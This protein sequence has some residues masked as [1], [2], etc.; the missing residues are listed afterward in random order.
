MVNSWTVWMTWIKIAKPACSPL[1]SFDTHTSKYRPL[2]LPPFPPRDSD[3]FSEKMETHPCNSSFK[4]FLFASRFSQHLLVRF[5]VLLPSP[6]DS[7][8]GAF[9]LATFL[10]H[11]YWIQFA[12]RPKCSFLFATTRSGIT[13]GREEGW[14]ETGENFIQSCGNR[15]FSSLRL[16]LESIAL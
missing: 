10:L 4:W 13:E 7:C 2:F 1:Y 5:C 12:L 15:S 16:R 8:S 6:I 9:F 14:T 3:D 11:L